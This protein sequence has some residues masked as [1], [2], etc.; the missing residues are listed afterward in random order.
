[1]S[2]TSDDDAPAPAPA[3]VVALPVVV[4]AAAKPKVVTSHPVASNQGFDD[5]GYYLSLLKLFIVEVVMACRCFLVS[6]IN[7]LLSACWA[8]IYVPQCQYEYIHCLF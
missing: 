7:D 2:L 5:T 8:N 3:R 1:M 6:N 4:A